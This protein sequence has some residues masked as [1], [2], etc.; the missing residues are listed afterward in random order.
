MFN[1]WGYIKFRIR[2]V[3]CVIRGGHYYK[4]GSF[5]GYR[6]LECPCGSTVGLEDSV[7][8]LDGNE[9]EHF[10]DKHSINDLPDST[11]G[12][13]QIEVSSTEVEDSRELH[14]L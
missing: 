9:R 11:Y 3:W 7:Y 13:L 8:D 14:G 12:Y 4:M 6:I 5:M 2:E 1:N 10:Y